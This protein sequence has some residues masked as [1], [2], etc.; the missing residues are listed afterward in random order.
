MVDHRDQ[1]GMAPEDRK[2]GVRRREWIMGKCASSVGNEGGWLSEARLRRCLP[3]RASAC[4]C[5]LL[6][7]SACLCVPLLA[8]SKPRLSSCSRRE[9]RVLLDDLDAKSSSDGPLICMS[10][11][12]E[13]GC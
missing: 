8:F 6:R 7:A 3:L 10:S 11:P 9:C 5:V 4:L 12:A 2:A 1:D 13:L